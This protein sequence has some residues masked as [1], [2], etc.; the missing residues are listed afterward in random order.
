MLEVIEAADG[1]Y[2]VVDDRGR[3]VRGF[4]EDRAR[5]EGFVEGYAEGRADGGAITARSTD[6]LAARIAGQR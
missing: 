4:G 3:L 5:A 6:G 2:Q 1:Q